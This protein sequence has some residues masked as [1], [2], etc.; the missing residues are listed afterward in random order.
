VAKFD[1]TILVQYRK[2][3]NSALNFNDFFYVKIGTIETIIF[4]FYSEVYLLARILESALFKTPNNAVESYYGVSLWWLFFGVIGL[5]FFILFLKKIWYERNKIQKVIAMFIMLLG[6]SLLFGGLE[7]LNCYVTL[8]YRAHSSNH[9]FICH[10]GSQFFYCIAI[11]RTI[12]LISA[13]II[14]RKIRMY[15]LG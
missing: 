12:Y 10:G 2:C 11:P 5:S 4:F 3:S 7:D 14:F 9:T 15:E 6:I 8:E 13:I 1:C